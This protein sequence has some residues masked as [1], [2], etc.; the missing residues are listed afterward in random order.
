MKKDKSENITFMAVPASGSRSDDDA[1]RVD[2][3]A[4]YTA[5]AVRSRH[6][7]RIKPQLLRS[8]FLQTSEQDI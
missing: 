2:H 6:Q 1:L 4:H 7:Y 3:L 8:D 5:T